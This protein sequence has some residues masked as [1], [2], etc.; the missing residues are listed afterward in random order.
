MAIEKERAE[1]LER[2]K[3]QQA[4]DATEHKWLQKERD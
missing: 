4:K 1:E 3:K 2:V